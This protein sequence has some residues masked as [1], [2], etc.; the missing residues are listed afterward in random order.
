MKNNIETATLILAII[1]A[2]ISAVSVMVSMVSVAVSAGTY[3]GAVKRNRRQATIDAYNR[4]QEQVFDPLNLYM[5]KEIVE[6]AKHPTDKQYKILSGYLARIEHF[7][8]GVMDE[9]YDPDTVYE[10]AH[11]YFDSKVLWSRI[12]PL[13]EAKNN[14]I[15]KE[16]Y[17]ENLHKTMRW[18][19][20][21][22][23]K[24]NK[25]RKNR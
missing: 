18:M 22:T 20:K 23:A 15:H 13:M 1:T 21:E 14:D 2:V 17:Y 25:K 24:R 4:L 7:C 12:S 11:G 16:D 9:T 19:E 6:Y 5:P 3:F 10:L 8:V